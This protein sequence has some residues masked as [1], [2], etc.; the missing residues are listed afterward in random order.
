[1]KRRKNSLV[2]QGSILAAA[3]IIV[4]IIGF[5]YRI[6]LNNILTDEG[7]SYYST[8]FIIYT[9]FLM[10]ST[11]GFPIAL[12]K[13]ISERMVEKKIK[14]VQV[15]FKSALSLAL[16]LGII[17][18]VILW[19]GADALAIY[20]GG[21]IK[22][23]LAI[24]AT[25]PALLIFSVLSVYRGYFQGMNTMVPTALS[26]IL[27]QIFNAGFS[28]LLAIILVKK[29]YE[30][31][32]AGG[33]IGTGIGALAALILLMFVYKV[34]NRKIISKKILKD[35]SNFE[36]KSLFFYWK[37]IL[38]VSIPIVIGTAILNFASVV[39][40]FMF[41]RAV[42]FHGLGELEA[43]KLFGLYATKNQLLINLPV[44]IAASLAMA[45]IPSI[46]AAVVNGSIENIR[47]KI[48][49]AIRGTILVVLPA[50][51]GEFVLAEPIINMLFTG[52]NLELAAK[53]LQIS[54]ISIVF[55]GLSTVSVGILQGLGKLKMQIWTSS[56]AL[57]IKIVFNVILLFV[58]NLNI[59]G[60]VIANIM[61]SF[62]YATLNIY[63]IN[64]Y[65]PIKINMK[66]SVIIPIA[67]ATLMGVTCYISYNALGIISASNTLATLISII[68]S[69]FVYCF[70]LL[71]LKGIT[72]KEII[73][74]PKG[75]KILR[76]LKRL[77]MM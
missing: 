39:D 3:A 43:E 24:R 36:K 28:L 25:A 40:M 23:A 32:A 35:K 65:V 18:S 12:S 5:F 27:E 26:Q 41:K 19:F 22:A 4:R 20:S 53:L 59:Y 56:I 69:I 16:I 54:A 37:L 11:Y 34:T 30:Y 21:S 7:N 17:F 10:I 61:F 44:T 47:T 45:S 73:D 49:A 58:F 14:E 74:F 1:M 63:I 29:G 8:A 31:G 2:L 76:L 6:P 38:M 50:A 67:A 52:E 72:E 55:F 62:I 68:I 13:L 46:S 9:F 57:I 15:I 75:Q 66:R 33:E 77:K 51:V 42:V 60:A 64:R 48:D 71:K 70:I